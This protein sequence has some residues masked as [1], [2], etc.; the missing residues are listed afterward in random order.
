MQEPPGSIALRVRGGLLVAL[1]SG[2][3]RLGT[4]APELLVRPAGHP[5]EL[6]WT[7]LRAARRA[8]P[9]RPGDDVL[10]RQPAPQDLGV[11]LRRRSRRAFQR[12]RVRR[13]VSRPS[14]RL[15]RRRRRLPVERGMGRRAW[16]ATRPLARWTA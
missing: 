3:F 13:A 11:R 5:P 6:R 15:V 8:L 10:R 9:D 16:C 4:E 1:Q 12:A 7:E 2:I 14:R